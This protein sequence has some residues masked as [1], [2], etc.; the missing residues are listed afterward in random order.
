MQ[1]TEKAKCYENVCV[2]RAANTA[3]QKKSWKICKQR[4]RIF[5]AIVLWDAFDDFVVIETFS[6]F[7]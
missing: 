2:E 3:K 1:R 6:I 4:K 5:W 7:L